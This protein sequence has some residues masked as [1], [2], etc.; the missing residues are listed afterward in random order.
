VL[1]RFAWDA[2]NAEPTCG[3]MASTSPRLLS[4]FEYPLSLTI[5][6]SDHSTEEERFIL[7]GQSTQQHLL[8]MAHVEHDATI[9]IIS[10]RTATRWERAFCKEGQ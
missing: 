2:R 4:A 9:R 8:V 6:D 3:S 7:V 1:H 5:P 10:A